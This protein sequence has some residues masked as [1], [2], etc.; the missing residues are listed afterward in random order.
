[1]KDRGK[2][3]AVYVGEKRRRVHVRA[4]GGLPIKKGQDMQVYARCGRNSDRVELI[5]CVLFP[6]RL[7]WLLPL[8]P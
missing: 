1:M 6:N 7:K 8:A 5:A 4:A 2:R 3:Y